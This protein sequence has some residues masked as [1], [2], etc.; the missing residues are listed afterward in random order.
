M[1]PG[2]KV[3]ISTHTDTVHVAPG[4]QR[5]SVIK[6]IVQLHEK[7]LISNCLGADDTAGIYAALRMIDA[8]VKA[9]FIF[10]RDEEIGGKGSTWL[11]K[12]HPEWLESFDICLALDRRGTGEIITSQWGGTCASGEFAASL[13]D[14][15]RMGH[16]AAAGIFTDSANYTGL[17]PECSNLSIGYQHE[18]TWNESLNLDYL[19]AVIE[20]LIM[21]DWGKLDVVRDPAAD[22]Y[23]W[24]KTDDDQLQQEY[25]V[26]LYGDEKDE[27]SY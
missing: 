18:H 19:D 11:A 24:W 6:G 16:R 23:L 15:L 21:V 3:M 17:I 10:H 8:G 14:A 5:V 13:G 22:E 9:T 2:A 12:T 20:R 7:E 25:L 1:C 27:L 4:M 26:D